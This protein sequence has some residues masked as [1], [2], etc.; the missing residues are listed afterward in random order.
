M[1]QFATH[2][3]WAVGKASEKVDST[4]TC[5]EWPRASGKAE[6]AGWVAL[7]YWGWEPG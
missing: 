1:P 7:G 6:G 2:G 3:K 4:T 5:R